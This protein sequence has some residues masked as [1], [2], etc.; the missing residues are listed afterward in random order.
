MDAIGKL[1]FSK[2]LARSFLLPLMAMI[3]IFALAYDCTPEQWKLL[4]APGALITG[5]AGIFNLNE[6]FKTWAT[7]DIKPGT[8]L[9]G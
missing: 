2:Y 4:W 9:G 8:I 3:F 5:C 1:D 6:A 7:K